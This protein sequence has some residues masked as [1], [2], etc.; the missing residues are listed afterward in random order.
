MEYRHPTAREVVHGTCRTMTVGEKARFAGSMF[1]EAFPGDVWTP[2]PTTEGFLESMVGSNHGE[3]TCIQLP[4]SADYEVERHM[5]KG[6]VVRRDWDRRH[7]PLD[8]AG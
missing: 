1:R 7:I 6:R 4:E 5:P 2:R 3:W 8:R